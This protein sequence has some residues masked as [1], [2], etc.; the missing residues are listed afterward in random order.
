MFTTVSSLVHFFYVQPP[1]PGR[2]L[3]FLNF[4]LYLFFQGHHFPC[5]LFYRLRYLSPSSFF[6][7][8]SSMSSRCCSWKIT[9]RYSG[10]PPLVFYPQLSGFFT[11]CA[12]LLPMDY[13]HLLTLLSPFDPP[14]ELHF[15]PKFAPGT[16]L[17]YRPRPT[18]IAFPS[19]ENQF[20]LLSFVTFCW[21]EFD[22]VK[23]LG[24][25][26]SGWW[27]LP[28][29][30][31]LFVFSASFLPFYSCFLMISVGPPCCFCLSPSCPFFPFPLAAVKSSG[32]SRI[33][34]DASPQCYI[35]F[36][37]TF[38]ALSAILCRAV[39]SSTGATN[40]PQPSYSTFAGL[41]T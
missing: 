21:H 33:L 28:S 40:F 7:L 25:S 23:F 37:F 11:C 34:L 19:Q 24:P 4:I 17:S 36:F 22:S 18:I 10:P 3:T 8:F 2:S 20:F 14:P 27:T 31:L 32:I 26:D 39:F 1:H 15:P 41:P 12:Q 16:C 6:H 9:L 35:V 30:E 13:R 38:L 5:F 29:W